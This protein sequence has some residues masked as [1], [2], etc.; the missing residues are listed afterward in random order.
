VIEHLVAT[1]ESYDLVARDYAEMVPPRFADDV[2][3]R[4]ML[5]AFGEM[6]EGTVADLGCGPGQVTAYLD[7]LG[8]DVFGVD[9]SPGMV[10][11]ARERYPALRFAVGSMAGLPVE[12]G[13]LG[14]IVAWWSIVHTP[15][16]ALPTIFAEFRR[17]LKPGGHVILGFHTGD[18]KRRPERAYGHPVTFD[19]YRFPVDRIAEE[20]GMDVTARLLLDDRQA[21]LLARLGE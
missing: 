19:T 20:L 18:S 1:R 7:G 10:G 15:P 13:T 2:I 5:A 12:D 6:V 3:G 11:V 17:T 8:L 4:A 9:I 16:A 21:C 14:G